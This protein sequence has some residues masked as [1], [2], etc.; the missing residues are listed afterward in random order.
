[1]R[2]LTASDLM[3]IRTL[4]ARHFVALSVEIVGLEASGVGASEA[5]SLVDAGI[6]SPE[7]M[8]ALDPI[9]DAYTLG[10]LRRR[11]EQAGMDPKTISLDDLHA[12]IERDPMPTTNAA[13]AAIQQARL[14]AGQHVVGIAGTVAGDI[15][16]ELALEA[17]GEGLRGAIGEQTASA[18]EARETYGALR[19]RL[20]DAAG[21]WSKDWLRVATTE[22]HEAQEQGYAQELGN[23]FGADARVALIPNPDACKHCRRLTVANGR[24]IIR[25]LSELVANGSNV[26]RKAADWKAVVGS[27]HPYCACRLVYVP[28]GMEF[29]E[30]WLLVATP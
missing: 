23:T 22:M 4:V 28:E 25:R 2:Q 17:K 3:D 13:T 14:W 1:M 27:I 6:L 8:G 29:N 5:Q 24:P 11:L 21:Q 16:R 9:K 19:T 18:M 30:K 7:A 15:I 26:G 20:G 12:M 10:F